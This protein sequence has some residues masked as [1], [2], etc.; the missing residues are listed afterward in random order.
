MNDLPQDIKPDEKVC[1]NCEHLAWMVGIGQ[2]LKCLNPDKEIKHQPIQH[3]RHTCELF[4]FK[5]DKK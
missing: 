2:G 1:F 5:K 3:R 4:E